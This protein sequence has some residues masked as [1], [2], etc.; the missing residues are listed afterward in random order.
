VAVVLILGFAISF[1]ASDFS[2]AMV[3]VRAERGKISPIKL[4]EN[5]M[6]TFNDK[7]KLDAKIESNRFKVERSAYDEKYIENPIIA[8][9]VTTKFHD[10]SIFFI[11]KI[12]DRN[13]EEVRR[14][15][16]DLFFM[17][18]PQPLL[19]KL[20]VGLNKGSMQYT[21][22]D[23]LSHYAIGTPLGGFRTGSMFAQ[24]LL[25]FGSLFPIIYFAMCFVLFSAI[26]LFSKKTT[27]GVV[28]ISA[29][30]MLNIWPNFLFG[31]TADSIHVLF[32]GVFRGVMQ[33][34]V[35]YF[36]AISIARFI[37]KA[38]SLKALPKPPAFK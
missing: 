18:L 17:A 33:S 5:T 19:D 32:I 7:A 13:I 29:I 37:T 9:L 26:D 6:E 20:K 30:G 3:I 24:G 8:R 2:Q 36:I 27:E 14:K 23:M 4:I 28:V 12:S 31:I 10:N 38:F 21:N 25:L 22:G 35:L 16:V 15:S 11:E 34:V 1:P